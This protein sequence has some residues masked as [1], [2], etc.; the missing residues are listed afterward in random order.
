MS[1]REGWVVGLVRNCRHYSKLTTFYVILSLTAHDF[2]FLL[3]EINFITLIHL[4]DL[5]LSSIKIIS[6]I[7][8]LRI[9]LRF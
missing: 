2:L 7:L 8:D 5:M 3:S 4:T 9:P 6:E 1:E